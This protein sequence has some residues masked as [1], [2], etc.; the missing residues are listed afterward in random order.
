MVNP[1]RPEFL[2]FFKP[3]IKETQLLEN[4]FPVKRSGVVNP[5]IEEL[6]EFI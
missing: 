3:Y 2:K 6:R 4:I 1:G 5:G